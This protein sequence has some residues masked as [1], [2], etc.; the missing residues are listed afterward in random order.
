MKLNVKDVPAFMDAVKRCQGDVVLTDWTVDSNGEP[1]FRLN[2]KSEISL[3]LGITKLLS[4]KGDWF[5][6]H[7]SRREDE[8]ILMP[9]IKAK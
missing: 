5:E 3:H 6:L 7:V 9:F 2:L 1:N 8:A 4:E